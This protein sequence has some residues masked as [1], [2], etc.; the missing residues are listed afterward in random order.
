M[1]IKWQIKKFNELTITELYQILQARV[2]VFVLEQNCA[3]QD[4]DG[5]DENSF[6]LFGIDT[7]IKNGNPIVAYLRILPPGISYKEP[8]LG[9]VITVKSVRKQGLGI[10]LMKRAIEFT[11][12]KYQGQGIRISGQLYLEKFYNNLGF[13]T[14]SDVYLEDDIEHV[15]M[16]KK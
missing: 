2:E 14:V 13:E 1:N 3:Y 10:E 12:N 7:E 8:S 9:R 5:K 11:E 4:I 16:L 6:H 15:E